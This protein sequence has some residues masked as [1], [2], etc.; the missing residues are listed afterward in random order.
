M[1]Q[2]PEYFIHIQEI[3]QMLEAD[4]VC[5]QAEAALVEDMQRA[6]SLSRASSHEIKRSWLLRG[7]VSY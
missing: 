6:C 3:E 1:P 4:A 7:M 5:S 2:K